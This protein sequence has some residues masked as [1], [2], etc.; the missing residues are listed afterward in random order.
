MI[1]RCRTGVSVT[2]NLMFLWQQFDQLFQDLHIKLGPVSSPDQRNKVLMR[3]AGETGEIRT[4]QG[5][6]QIQHRCN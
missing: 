2:S 6:V 3:T 1:Q 5:Q 4:G